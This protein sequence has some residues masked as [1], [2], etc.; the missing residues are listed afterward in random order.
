LPFFVFISIME[1]KW[2]PFILGH[3]LAVALA[4]LA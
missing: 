4:G 1:T 2:V 3:R